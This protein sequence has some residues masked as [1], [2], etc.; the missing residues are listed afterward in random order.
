MEEVK[1]KKPTVDEF[2]KIL[3]HP[4]RRTIIRLLYERVEMTYSELVKELSINEGQFNF[5]LRMVKKLTKMT[6]DGKYSLSS[7]GR[8]T[9]DIFTAVENHLNSPDTLT[10]PP[11][12]NRDIIIRRILAFIID[13]LVFATATGL[14]F[15]FTLLGTVAHLLTGRIWELPT[16]LYNLV[17]TAQSRYTLVILAIY[18]A[19]TLFDSLKGQTLGRYVMGIRVVTVMNRRLSLIESAT[20]NIG[21]IFLLPMDLIV[22]LV[23]FYERGYIKFFDYLTN[24]KTERVKVDLRQVIKNFE[25]ELARSRTKDT[26]SRT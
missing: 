25:Q 7:V 20:R 23:F 2:Y 13:V 15:D 11:A 6:T 1:E 5:H 8:V 10:P 21:K 14:I 17:I 19:F 24:C 22:G 16:L 3:A 26:A 12:L 4:A 18:I 9:Y